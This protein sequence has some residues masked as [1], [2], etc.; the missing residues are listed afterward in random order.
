MRGLERHTYLMW[1]TPYNV[2]G[3]K[4]WSLW[5]LPHQ[6]WAWNTHIS[7]STLAQNCLA[8]SRS[9]SLSCVFVWQ[10]SMMLTWWWC[11][12]AWGLWEIEYTK[13]A[14]TLHSPCQADRVPHKTWSPFCWAEEPWVPVLPSPCSCF[15]GRT[16][17][18]PQDDLVLNRNNSCNRDQNLHNYIFH[19]SYNS[20]LG[21]RKYSRNYFY[22]VG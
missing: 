4:G 9:A 20:R 10:M 21:L 2:V 3:R 13:C 8:K 14:Q 15:G 17:T 1:Q 12:F 6:I 19:C 5:V 16:T 22:A 11:F 18:L 7:V